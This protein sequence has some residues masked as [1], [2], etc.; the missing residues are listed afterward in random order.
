MQVE[1][2]ENNFL[3][4]AGRTLQAM[5]AASR[6]LAAEAFRGKTLE[7]P[8]YNERNGFGHTYYCNTGF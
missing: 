1:L 2:L 5:V 7:M 3:R 8:R 6:E 4:R